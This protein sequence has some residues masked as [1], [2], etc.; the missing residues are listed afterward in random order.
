MEPDNAN[1]A[2]FTAM[3]AN[4][5][6]KLDRALSELHSIRQLVGPFAATFP[7]GSMLC[8]SIHGIKYFIDPDDLVIAPQMVVYRQWEAGL[9]EL[10]GRL[11]TSGTV[12]VDVGA[13][14]G[15]FSCLAGSLIGSSGH[16][17]VYAFEPN[18]KLAKLARRNIEINWSM[19]PVIFHENAVAD[20]SGS[21]QLHV[22]DAHGANAS[23]SRLKE[24]LQ[25]ESVAVEAVRLDDIIPEDVRGCAENRC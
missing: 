8:Q 7:D 23:L 15:Y 24:G 10:F 2:T 13:N 3:L 20:F 22:P 18:P 4:L 17:R 1:D 9:S 12:V 16:G 19:A 14:F 11:C 21:V 25:G 6:Q 5:E